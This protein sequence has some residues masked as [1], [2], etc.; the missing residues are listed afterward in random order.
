MTICL[1][2][3]FLFR[4]DDWIF[5]PD[6]WIMVEG[7]RVLYFDGLMD[8]PVFGFHERATRTGRQCEPLCCYCFYRYIVCALLVF[9]SWIYVIVCLCFPPTTRKQWK[10]NFKRHYT[11]KTNASYT[12]NW[13]KSIYTNLAV[14]P[15]RNCHRSSISG[16]TCPLHIHT[17]HVFVFHKHVL[18]VSSHILAW[19]F[20]TASTSRYNYYHSLPKPT[21]IP[22]YTHKAYIA[23]CKTLSTSRLSHSLQI[24]SIL[25][26][27]N[28][29]PS[30]LTSANHHSALPPLGQRRQ[31]P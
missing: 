12:W 9:L 22:K 10:K 31:G 6:V 24:L 23:P 28:E 1:G 16:W 19:R 7:E 27:S 17:N 25:E 4:S 15:L 3:S 14:A 2:F 11:V 29:N 5:I 13:F 20:Q 18:W 8:I 21:Y 26:A 30:I